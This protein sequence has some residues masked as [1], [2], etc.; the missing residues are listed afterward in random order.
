[1]ILKKKQLIG[2]TNDGLNS[3]WAGGVRAIGN[4]ALIAAD[5]GLV[6]YDIKDPTKPTLKYVCK[7]GGKGK[8]WNIALDKSSN[9]VFL[10]DNEGLISFAKT[11]AD[12]GVSSPSQSITMIL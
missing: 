2:K 11:L 5:P 7:M 6:I 3:G 8:G 9:T 1:M 12:A 10:A 4:L